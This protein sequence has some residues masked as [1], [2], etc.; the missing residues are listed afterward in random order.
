[1]DKGL[2]FSQC[3]RQDQ[4]LIMSVA[5]EHAFHVL[6]LPVGELSEWVEQEVE[7]NPILHLT[8]HSIQ[9]FNLSLIHSKPTLYEH[10]EQQITLHFTTNEDKEIARYL[11]GS[12]DD[13]GLLTLSPEEL[14]GKEKVLHI[15]QR[16]D[17]LGIGA[18]SIQEAL[19]I[20]LEETKESLAYRIVANHF[21]DLLHLRL[22]K[23]RK[24]LGLS[25]N[26]IKELIHTK[27][28]PLTP[29]PG[30]GFQPT[31]NPP[32]IP[33]VT[34]TLE[35][36][37]W[38]IDVNSSLIPTFQ[39]HPIYLNALEGKGLSK[40]ESETIRRYLAAGKWLTRILNRRKKTL[41]DIAIYLLKKE[42]DFLEGVSTAPTPL[43]MREVA[44]ALSLSEATVT[45]AIA[46]KSVATPRGILSLRSFFT[47]GITT[48]KGTI[49]NKVAK[50]LLKT[51]IKQE[52]VPLSDAALS[53]ELKARGIPCARR[54]VAK[55]R[56]ELKIGSASQRKLWKH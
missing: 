54:T 39:I 47:Q 20:Q 22:H 30:R 4:R 35:E 26:Q 37:L 12:L 34:I 10:L 28:R 9:E 31:I 16:M 44:E 45:R 42:K 13:K 23:I 29:Y 51:L 21:E 41:Q 56:K 38:N 11:A 50:D 24:K 36:E 53:K 2:H 55:Y 52:K 15:F 27:L 48:E 25:E 14:K 43:T 17:P 32:L 18:R 1:M 46:N 5:M 19:L 3:I 7:K 33:D 8:S 40:D 6:Q 49:S